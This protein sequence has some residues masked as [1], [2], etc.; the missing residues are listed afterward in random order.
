[1]S[2]GE[3]HRLKLK[4]TTY[5]K[6]QEPER[7]NHQIGVFVLDRHIVDTTFPKPLTAYM[8]LSLSLFLYL[9]PS[10]SLFL[11][12]S[13]LFPYIFPLISLSIYLFDPHRVCV[14][15]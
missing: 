14:C 8:S 6:Q 7:E 2:H 5:A 13:F 1:M 15:V 11:S 4:S 12:L 9:S 10:R 3:N